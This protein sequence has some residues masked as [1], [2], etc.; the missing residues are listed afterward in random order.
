MNKKYM[1]YQVDAFT[2]TPFKGNPAGVVL[3]AEGLTES[4]MQSIQGL[5]RSQLRIRNQR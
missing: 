1:L 3:D 2:D 4:Q 5:A